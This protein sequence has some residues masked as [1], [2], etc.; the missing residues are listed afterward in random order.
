MSKKCGC[1]KSRHCNFQTICADITTNEGNVLLCRN[2]PYVL[3]PY[4]G[5]KIS[6]YEANSC[7][8]SKGECLGTIGGHCFVENGNIGP[9]GPTGPAGPTG[10][11]GL[12][13][14]IGAT[15]LMGPPGP[16]G[17]N[18]AT[19]AIGPTG[20][21][22]SNGP[23]GKMGPTG[24][25]GNIGPMGPTGPT[26]SNG[27]DGAMGPTGP[28][29]LN[30]IDGAIGPTGPT[31]S[32][33]TD[34]AMGP[35]G[36]AGLNGM[37]GAEGT[38]GEM[39]ATGPTGADFTLQYCQGSPTDVGTSFSYSGSYFDP[40]TYWSPVYTW[41]VQ[42]P[43]PSTLPAP[44]AT[45]I[46]TYFGCP[47]YRACFTGTLLYSGFDAVEPPD[48]GNNW[49]LEST[50][51]GTF[52]LTPPNT[53]GTVI[54]YGGNFEFDSAWNAT[55]DP[56]PVT[57][58]NVTYQSVPITAANQITPT[59]NNYGSLQIN[60]STAYTNTDGQILFNTQIDGISS[61]GLSTP[62]DVPFRLW[63]DYTPAGCPPSSK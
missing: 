32:N 47:L 19:G 2:G 48:D 59:S 4:T 31:G 60:G 24:S 20:P 6:I 33:G 16:A 49:A 45:Q 14:A 11:A 46:G 26:G 1:P 35:T 21:S 62:S 9:M 15:G 37:D 53:A 55:T 28:A 50:I 39:G 54:D 17:L 63:V 23:T 18:G 30:G 40:E 7:G 38:A 22:G 27:I 41:I 56:P 25:N 3:I 58:Q 36:P 44:N 43:D 13:G 51:S 61:G 42:D 57:G 12:N 34:G 8:C 5:G 10:L 52:I 29:G